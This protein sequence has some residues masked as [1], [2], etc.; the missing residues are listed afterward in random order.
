MRISARTLTAAITGALAV[1]GPF[2]ACP[3]A[4]AVAPGSPHGTKSATK[5]M[6]SVTVI[7][8]VKNVMDYPVSVYSGEG[9]AWFSTTPIAPHSTET[10]SMR[11][12][13]VGNQDEMNK[14]IQVYKNGR[15]QYGERQFF[16]Y[17]IFQDYWEPS[18]QV[19]YG[20]YN[21]YDM[22]RPLPVPGDSTGGGKKRLIIAPDRPYMEAIS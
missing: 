8:E 9:N 11:V 1:G 20:F 13:W 15:D 5:A 16:L 6:A 3:S 21:S 4:N 19:K 14:D 2:T 7:A 17:D 18:D 12:P 22:P 10:G